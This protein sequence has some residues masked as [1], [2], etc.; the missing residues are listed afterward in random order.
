MTI[1]T[2]P[3]DDKCHKGKKKYLGFGAAIR[4]AENFMR[5]KPKH[6]MEAYKCYVCGFYHI[7][8]ARDLRGY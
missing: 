4:A 8:H 1:I 5:S 2:N 6:T 3:N 7:G